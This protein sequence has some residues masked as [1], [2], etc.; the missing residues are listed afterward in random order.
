MLLKE[1]TSPIP[2][3]PEK[4]AWWKEDRKEQHREDSW[5]AEAA[6]SLVSEGLWMQE[7]KEKQLQEVASK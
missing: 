7:S 3:E 6:E 4:L 1:H 5:A 2:T